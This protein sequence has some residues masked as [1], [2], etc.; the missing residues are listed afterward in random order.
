MSVGNRR[1]SAA[2]R[3]AA[4]FLLLVAPAAFGETAPPSAT[5][6]DKRAQTA[7]ELERIEAEIAAA[8]A[9]V[10]ALN[11][12]AETLAD[13]SKDLRRQ[14]VDAASK[15]QDQERRL[16]DV[17][18]R[19]YV[20]VGRESV[21]VD[22]LKARQATIARLV[23][24]LESLSISRPPALG[25][26]PDDATEAARSAMLLGTIIPELR[27]QAKILETE[28][29]ELTRLRE[30]IRGEQR[31]AAAAARA[32]ETDRTG[33]EAKLNELA[34]RRLH[35]MASAQEE[36][37]RL[38]QLA[39][40][41]KDLRSFLED[42][43]RRQPRSKPG[44]GDMASFIPGQFHRLKGTLRPPVAGEIERTF[45]A[46]SPDGSPSRG[47]VFATR[48]A[49]QVVAPSAGTVVFSGPFRG[50][51]L[52]L[53]IQADDGYH[54][55]L[56]GMARIDAVARQKLLAGEPVGIMGDSASDPNTA[57]SPELYVELRRRGEPVDPLPW[58]APIGRK[59][60]G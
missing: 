5:P 4:I 14:L 26:S 44:M 42:L 11:K 47:V 32:L 17:E 28:L 24:A 45:G 1:G 48:S 41:A 27:G 52:L 3:C 21:L 9:R 53:I 7:E 54:F 60:S 59:V 10:E 43:A 29:A 38:G 57:R 8:R 16:S 30:G 46:A 25:V 19:L 12:E 31:D 36:Q 2:I 37:S 15:V 33:L 23:G 34:D 51:G 39:Q 22:N 56:S 55:V 20:L 13:Q 6:E 18:S 35:A 49:A 50:Y 40:N 58:L